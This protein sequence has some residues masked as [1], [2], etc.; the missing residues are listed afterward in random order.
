MHNEPISP[1]RQRMLDAMAVRNFSDKTRHDYIRH[2]TRR[3]R[4]ADELMTLASIHSPKRSGSHWLK[5]EISN[6]RRRWLIFI[7]RGK[8]CSATPRRP[9]IGTI[10]LRWEAMQLRNPPFATCISRVKGCSAI[11]R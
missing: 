3:S 4:M 5:K 6:H 8:V 9:A 1:L 10:K 2:V 11:W 7:A